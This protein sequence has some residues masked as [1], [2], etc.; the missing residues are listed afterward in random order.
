MA[1]EYLRQAYPL[2]WPERQARTLS[3]SRSDAMFKVGLGKSRDDLMRELHLL[4]A[5]DI[6]V[7][8]NVP[9]RRDGL[10]LSDAR[11]PNDP[12]VAIYFDRMVRAPTAAAP[13]KKIARPFVI[14]CD[15]YRKV[16]WNLR[17]VGLTV[18]ALRAIERHGS[19][20]LLEQAFT[21]FAALPAHTEADPPWWVVLGVDEHAGEAVVREAYLELAKLHHPDAGGNDARMSQINRARDNAL[22]AR[23]N[24]AQ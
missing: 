9:V 15:H 13:W 8:T 20:A 23:T 6:V 10:P 1:G 2:T 4:G 19:S 12:G 16:A 7:S 11:E 22:G 5:K 18:E 3:S 17:A 21:G 14:A 24:G